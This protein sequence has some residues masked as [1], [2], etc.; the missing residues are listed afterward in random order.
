MFFKIVENNLKKEFASY[1][2]DFSW[3]DDYTYISMGNISKYRIYTIKYCIYKGDKLSQLNDFYVKYQTKNIDEIEKYLNDIKALSNK[4]GISVN[5]SFLIFNLSQIV[6]SYIAD[7]NDKFDPD[8]YDQNNMIFKFNNYFIKVHPTCCGNI[9]LDG[10]YYLKGCTSDT[11]ITKDEEIKAVKIINE[12]E[13]LTTLSNFYHNKENIV[14]LTDLIDQILY[15]I[16]D[17]NNLDH[18]VF[19][20]KLDSAVL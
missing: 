7:I 4:T 12:N 16:K 1:D 3:K 8:K 14:Y 2:L 5:K 15:K 13:K 18:D 17:Q 6:L 11:E 9:L 19:K 20:S 10:I